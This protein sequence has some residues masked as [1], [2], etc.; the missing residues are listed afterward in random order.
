MWQNAT[1]RSAIPFPTLDGLVLRATDKALEGLGG[2]DASP[3]VRTH[4]PNVFAVLGVTHERNV[5]G[6]G[7]LLGRCL[8]FGARGVAPALPDSPVDTEAAGVG[9]GRVVP[10]MPRFATS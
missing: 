3:P 5:V 6:N 4:G 1:S 8:A 2:F 7:Y 10:V 9:L